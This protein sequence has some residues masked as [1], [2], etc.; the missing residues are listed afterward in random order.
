M[1]AVLHSNAAGGQLLQTV[2]FRT[3]CSDPLAVG[4]QFGAA[5]LVT[6]DAADVPEPPA[7]PADTNA[8]GV[9]DSADLQQFLML[10]IAGSK[11]AD[12]NADGLIDLADLAAFI[13][14]FA[15]AR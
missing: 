9:V 6:C 12:L 8:D 13:T 15:D 14:V 2:E 11:E 3:G 1:L 5:L 10:Y 7:C 4:D